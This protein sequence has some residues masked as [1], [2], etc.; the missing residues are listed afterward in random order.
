MAVVDA[1]YKFLAV[2]IGGYGSNSDGGIFKASQIGSALEKKRLNLPPPTKL[3]RSN[4]LAPFVFLGDEA[5]QL[6][7]NFFRPYSSKEL[8]SKSR[9]FNY[10][11]SRARYNLKSFC[12]MFNSI[13]YQYHYL[14]YFSIYFS[15]RR[16][17][18]NAFG[19]LGARWRIFHRSITLAPENVD[20]VIKATVVLHNF[21]ISKEKHLRK[22]QKVYCPSG[23]ADFT[24]SLGEYHY[25]LWNDEPDNAL[26]N[27][28]GTMA[29]NST[30][31]AKQCRKLYM[32]YFW[33]EEGAVPWQ[34]DMP[35]VTR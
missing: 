30:E 1:D 4:N 25:G 8:N 9:V 13:N 6:Q 23:Y 2:D 18:E 32:D 19:I 15:P 17:S 11:L 3:P 33:S 22:K 16:C 21:L 10:R 5:F 34:W 29:R 20:R 35:G 7:E 31:K 14:Y 12:T 27:L 26:F 28:Q 24:D